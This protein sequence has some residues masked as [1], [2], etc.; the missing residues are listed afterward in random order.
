MIYMRINFSHSPVQCFDAPKLEAQLKMEPLSITGCGYFLNAGHVLWSLGR[1]PKCFVDC[2]LRKL[3]R[4]FVEVVCNF[5]KLC[6][7][8]EGY[9]DFKS[10][11]TIIWIWAISYTS[12]PHSKGLLQAER[13]H[14]P[15]K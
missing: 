5:D 15:S 12:A 13:T 6:Y 9:G 1:F 3:R 7:F 2:Y 4:V 8:L 10:A 11:G 14:S